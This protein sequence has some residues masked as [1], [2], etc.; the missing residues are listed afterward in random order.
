MLENKR[1]AE[2]QVNVP[3]SPS[4]IDSNDL[5]VLFLQTRPLNHYCHQGRKYKS[6]Y[7]IF[8]VEENGID[9]DFSASQAKLSRRFVKWEDMDFL[10]KLGIHFDAEQLKD[11][12]LPTWFGASA[13]STGGMR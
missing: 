7:H 3:N 2:H 8:T 11:I 1:Y 10:S 4:Q 13:R 6:L 12:P 5:A 9:F